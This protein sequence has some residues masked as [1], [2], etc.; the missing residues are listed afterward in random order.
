[1]A[2]WYRWIEYAAFGPVLERHRILYFG[3]LSHAERILVLGEGD[4]RSL[5]HVL[6]SSFAAQVDVIDSSAKMIALAKSRI[7]PTSRVRFQCANA[8]DRTWA[9]KHY[10]AIVTSFFLDCFHED[11]ARALMRGLAESLRPGGIWLVNEFA[12]PSSGW[13]KWKAQVWISTMYR[14]FGL[15]TGLR[16]RKLPPI[17]R[18]MTELGMTRTDLKESFGRMVASEV[19]TKNDKAEPATQGVRPVR[20]QR[21]Q[22]ATLLAPQ[23]CRGSCS[24]RPSGG[25]CIF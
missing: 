23:S 16:V 7:A 20:V 1:M 4:G 5:V 19:W 22:Y 10:D 18:L 24:S 14:F 13:R 3:R 12:I 15:T 11:E 9:E 8:L 2:P 6:N 25:V 17:G 21:T